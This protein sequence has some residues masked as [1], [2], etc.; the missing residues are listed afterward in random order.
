[1]RNAGNQALFVGMAGNQKAGLLQW[2]KHTRNVTTA[3][4]ANSSDSFLL[5][6]ERLHPKQKK[7]QKTTQDEGIIH[8]AGRP[9]LSRI[10]TRLPGC[11][12]LRNDLCF[13][14]WGIVKLYALTH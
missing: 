3:A 7:T 6:C 4:G 2:P 9:L 12:R 10:C 13:V 5:L 8:V 1:M 14:G 11:I